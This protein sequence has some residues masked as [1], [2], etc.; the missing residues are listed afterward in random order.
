MG[1]VYFV[2]DYKEDGLPVALK[3]FHRELL[4][5][6]TVR[7]QFLKEVIVCLELGSHHILLRRSGLMI[8]TNLM[9]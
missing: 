7:D 3:T 1:V 5:R 9:A 2:V 8:E 6:R 4:K